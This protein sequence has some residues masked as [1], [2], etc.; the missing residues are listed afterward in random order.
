MFSL[1]RIYL[2]SFVN[3]FYSGLQTKHNWRHLFLFYI[4]EQK[5]YIMKINKGQRTFQKVYMK[6]LEIIYG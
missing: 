3:N 6:T 5:Y 2:V 1:E 4:E